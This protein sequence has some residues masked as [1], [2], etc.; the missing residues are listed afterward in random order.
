[1]QVLRAIVLLVC[2]WPLALVA[3]NVIQD[4]GV[5]MSKQELEYLVKYWT[6][7]MQEAAANDTGNRVELLNMALANKKMADEA[8][9]WTPDE[10]PDDY[11]RYQFYIRNELRK[12]VVDK[13]LSQIVVPDMTALAKERY[14][15]NKEQYATIPEQRYVSHI[16]IRCQE[17]DCSRDERRPEAEK[18]LAELEGGARFET[19]VATYSDDTGSKLRDGKVDRWMRVDEPKIDPYFLMGVYALEKEG[20]HSGLVESNFGFHIIRLDDIREESYGSYEEV[21]PAMINELENEYR[22]LAAKEFDARY[23]LSDK[24]YIDGAA[25]EEIFAPYKS[26]EP[27]SP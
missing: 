22:M 26:T 11:W 15:S 3:Q 1:M 6:P 16:L 23:R 18:V 5:G 19:L 8:N 4:E 17:A 14:A 21:A 7:Q 9:H 13:A 2:L 25:M 12:Y 27:A 24:A 10:N 20:D